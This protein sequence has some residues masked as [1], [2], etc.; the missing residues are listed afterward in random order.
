MAVSR[1]EGFVQL[2]EKLLNLRCVEMIVI[3]PGHRVLVALNSG[4]TI[5]LYGEEAIDFLSFLGNVMDILDEAED[6]WEKL[7]RDADEPLEDPEW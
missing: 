6:A 1:R 7:E 3:D 4:R 2:G 5:D